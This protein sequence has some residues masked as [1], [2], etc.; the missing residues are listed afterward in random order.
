MTSYLRFGATDFRPLRQPSKT[1]L[2]LDLF[3]SSPVVC[4][5]VTQSRHRTGSPEP[6]WLR[7]GLRLD[8]EQSPGFWHTLQLVIATALETDPRPCDKVSNGARDE[9]L[10]C[11]RK[12]GNACCNV[13]GH[14]C[15]VLTSKLNLAG[16]ETSTK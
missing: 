10:S 12:C 16:M 3:G 15:Y 7:A 4:R 9:H 8:G 2:R 5:M 13:H 14:A 11:D 6:A 1:R